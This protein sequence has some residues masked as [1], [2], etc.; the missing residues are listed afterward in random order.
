[1]LALKNNMEVYDEKKKLASVTAEAIGDRE[2]GETMP[3]LRYLK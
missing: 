2:E 3:M 1:M